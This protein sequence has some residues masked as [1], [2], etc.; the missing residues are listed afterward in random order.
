MR[1]GRHP[2]LDAARFLRLRR[3]KAASA[4]EVHTKTCGKIEARRTAQISSSP[5]F[6]SKRA[7][8][9]FPV[10][11]YTAC[12]IPARHSGAGGY[13][14]R[15]RTAVR[16]GSDR[17]AVKRRLGAAELT[18]RSGWRRIYPASIGCGIAF[19]AGS[20]SALSAIRRRTAARSGMAGMAP[21]FST[22][23]EATAF[24]KRAKD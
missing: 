17:P 24:P 18:R 16:R 2:I 23:R 9:I 13:E 21:R 15:N 1:S 12:A 11:S 8:P 4:K 22:H 14:S 6:C 7:F 5:R 10:S 20:Q 3:R 19:G